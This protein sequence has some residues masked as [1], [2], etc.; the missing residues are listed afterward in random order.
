MTYSITDEQA[1]ALLRKHGFDSSEMVP[2]QFYGE[3]NFVWLTPQVALRVSTM[4]AYESDAHNERIFVPV[5]LDASMPCPKLQVFDE[6]REIVHQRLPRFY[7][8]VG[9]VPFWSI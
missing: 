9:G 7:E 5:A 3:A 6:D 1:A 4:Q 8:R 2:S